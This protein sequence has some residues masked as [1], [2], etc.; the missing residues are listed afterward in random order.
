MPL[1]HF[2]NIPIANANWEPVFKNLFEV[3][4]TLPDILTN[5]PKVTGRYT[6]TQQYLRESCTKIKLPTYPPLATVDQRYKY[7]TRL[8]VGFPAST[9]ITDLSLTFNINQDSTKQMFTFAMMKDWY[10]LLWN[11][12]DGS[13]HL[14]VNTVGGIILYQHDREG[15]I[16]R[17]VTYHNCQILSFADGGDLAWTETTGIQ[18]LTAN[19]AVDWWE[20]YY[21]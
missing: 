18:E 15:N 14:K 4:I 12:E 10:D 19:F 5:F 17:R 11:N 16:I 13:S 6:N 8:F 7:S 2:N 21:F 20:D 9:S 1:P 3:D